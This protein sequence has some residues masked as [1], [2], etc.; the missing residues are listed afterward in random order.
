MESRATMISLG[1]ATARQNEPCRR[2]TVWQTRS[3][4]LAPGAPAIACAMTAVS[5]VAAV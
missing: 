4:M 2:G 3:I 5:D 1:V